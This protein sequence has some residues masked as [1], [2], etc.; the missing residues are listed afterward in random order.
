MAVD[1]GQNRIA[2]DRAHLGPDRGPKLGSPRIVPATFEVKDTKLD[3][4]SIWSRREQIEI[5]LGA[6]L[7]GLELRGLCPAMGCCASGSQDN[8]E[9]R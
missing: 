5:A 3:E 8:H 2:P 9:Q 7:L 6:P 1:L 4:A